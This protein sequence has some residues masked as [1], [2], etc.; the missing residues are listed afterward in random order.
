MQKYQSL[1]LSLKRRMDILQWKHWNYYNEYICSVHSSSKIENYY[2]SHL[3]NFYTNSKNILLRPITWFVLNKMQILINKHDNL[4][5]I[6][7]YIFR[8]IAFS[9][10][11]IE[12]IWKMS[13]L[14]SLII[15][16]SNFNYFRSTEWIYLKPFVHYTL[17][18]NTFF[19]IKINLIFIKI[20]KLKKKI[21]KI[22]G[23]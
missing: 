4:L 11:V 3:L 7:K 17:H 9:Y 22:W 2:K 18:Y 5:I 23:R 1:L 8:F 6:L 16:H 19:E 15:E 21:K 20:K 10:F 13:K 14:N 12:S